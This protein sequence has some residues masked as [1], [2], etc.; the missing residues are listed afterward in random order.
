MASTLAWTALSPRRWVT[1]CAIAAMLHR[2]YGVWLARRQRLSLCEASA[3]SE[4]DREIVVTQP[5]ATNRR[6]VTEDGGS[7]YVVAHADGPCYTSPEDYQPPTDS[8][9]LVH[10]D[11]AIAV[12]D[13]PAFLP[14]ENTRHIKDSAR[15]QLE[16]LLVAR[17]ESVS[18]LRLPHRLDWETSGLLVF[19]RGSQAMRSL[20][21][22]F[23]ARSVRK[24]YIADVLGA[25]PAT[26]GVVDLP[27]ASDAQRLP[28]QR[29]DFSEAGRPAR[30]AWEV[31]DGGPAWEVVGGAPPASSSRRH[32][33]TGGCRLRLRPE[34]GRRHQLRMHCLALGCPIACDMLYCRECLASTDGQGAG[35]G[36]GCSNEAGKSER[37]GGHGGQRLHLHAAEL[38]FV[39]PLTNQAVSFRSEP[40]FDLAS[41]RACPPPGDGWTGGRETRVARDVE[42][43]GCRVS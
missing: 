19:A 41:V 2:V 31:V 36:G 25:P 18:D 21:M 37:Q 35:G 43:A 42:R 23:A 27:L 4:V 5:L 9:K 22:Q 7:T 30:T 24:V 40:P 8:L 33:T 13:K 29:V 6:L 32:A 12:V 39:H 16:R 17:G 38:S 14:T 3:T 28:M 1:A 10:L 15:Q 20:A 26:R 11:E 34:S